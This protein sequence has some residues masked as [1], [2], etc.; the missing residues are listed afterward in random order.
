MSLTDGQL[1]HYEDHGF[2]IVEGLFTLEHFKVAKNLNC[3]IRY[4]YKMLWS[5]TVGVRDGAF[6]IP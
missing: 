5:M 3:V 1:R 6:L 4:S 2:V